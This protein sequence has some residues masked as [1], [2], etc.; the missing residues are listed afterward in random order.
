M[1]TASRAVP[2]PVVWLPLSVMPEPTF[3]DRI[4]ALTPE[5]QAILDESPPER[6]AALLAA[7][8]YI[9]R[10]F[11]EQNA[12]GVDLSLIA[13][14]LR[15]TPTQRL[16]KNWEHRVE[17]NRRLDRNRERYGF[18]FRP[19]NSSARHASQK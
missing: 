8:P 9:G 3:Q 11:P 1:T 2:A 15:L 10:D 5:Q 18:D 4:D 6:R 14:Q 13:A 12:D 17:L 16:Q 7:L 19:I